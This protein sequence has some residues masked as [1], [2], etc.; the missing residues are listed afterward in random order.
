[1]GSRKPRLAQGGPNVA[2]EQFAVSSDVAGGL[3]LVEDAVLV[4]RLGGKVSRPPWERP[5]DR[6][7]PGRGVRVGEQM[8]VDGAGQAAS[9]ASTGPR[10]RMSRAST[11]S[12]EDVGEVEIGL[13]LRR[14]RGRRPWRR[15]ARWPGFGR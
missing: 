15:R 9:R 12:L 2:V 11:W 1:M 5:P 7:K 6:L 10:R 8:G 3:D 4:Q 14:G 13:V